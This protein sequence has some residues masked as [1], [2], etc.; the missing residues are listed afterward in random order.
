M[1]RTESSNITQSLEDG[2]F[3]VEDEIP[4]GTIDGSNMSFT[5]ANSPNPVNSLEVRKNGL[6]MMLTE[7]YSL[8]GDT[9]TLVVAPRTGMNLRVDYRVEP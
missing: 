1:A 8:S 4:T 9:L 7:E 5:L 6:I 3:F 2:T